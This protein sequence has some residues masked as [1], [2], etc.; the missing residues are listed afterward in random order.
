MQG[1]GISGFLEARA[2]AHLP[3]VAVTYTVFILGHRSTLSAGLI[4]YSVEEDQQMT[5][6]LTSTHPLRA[7]DSQTPPEVPPPIPPEIPPVTIPPEISPEG[8]P[9]TTPPP[10]ELPPGTPVEIPSPSS[11]PEM[12]A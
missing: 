4:P 8:P 6:T 3:S 10:L 11:P 1:I 9:D 5:I 12:S 2:V 7:G